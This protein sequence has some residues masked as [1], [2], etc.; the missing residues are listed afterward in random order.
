MFMRRFRSG[1]A[2]VALTGISLLGLNSCREEAPS[3]NTLKDA[4]EGKFTIG[5]ALNE[6]QI[7]NMDTASIRVVKE[8]FN[9]ITAENCMKSG[10]I[11]PTEGNFSFELADKFVEF[12]V[13]NNM[14]IIGHTLVWHSQAPRWFFTDEEGND[15]SAEVLKERMKNHIYTVV[16]RYKGKIHGWDVVN[17]AILDDGS[18]RNSKYYQ[19]LGEEFIALAFQYAHEA[20][21]DCELYYNDYSMA[22]PGKREGVV[23]MIKMLKDK[24]LR[25]DAVGMQAH[26]A[27]DEPKIEEF[28]ASIKAFSEAGVKVMI[29]EMDLTVLEM[30]DF[31]VGAE[32]SA[33]FEYQQKL[34]PYS[35]GLPDSVALA[36]EERYLDFFKL[37]LKYDDAVTRVTLWGVTDNQSWKNNWPVRGRTDYPLLFDRNYQPKPVVEKIINEALNTK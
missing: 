17:E 19:I 31:R 35:E 28:E 10:P 24:G 16:G 18:Y 2:C 32:I 29:T 23:R 1:I 3:V 6:P 4:Y 12:G 14:E 8:H 20:D 15:V 21:P 30:P 5:A 33:N 7:L 13:A 36:F 25:I 37:F 11:Q 27:L 22:N 34:N 9:S 26:V